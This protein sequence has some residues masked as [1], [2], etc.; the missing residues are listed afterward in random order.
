[1]PARWHPVSEAE[2]HVPS[3]PLLAASGAAKRCLKWLI[4]LEHLHLSSHQPSLALPAAG[5][6]LREAESPAASKESRKRIASAR[7][8]RVRAT[9]AGRR[10]A[11]WAVPGSV[12][13]FRRPHR[14][15][16]GLGQALLAALPLYGRL[17]WRASQLLAALAL[18]GDPCCQGPTSGSS[19][20]PSGPPRSVHMPCG[21]WPRA[22]RPPHSPAT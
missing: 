14:G 5:G 3:A 7:A 1:L 20:Q 9:R 17:A 21:M 18:V 10:L 13:A 19:R 8:L 12:S 6:R 4:P 15:D 22:S 2:H 11:A 16:F